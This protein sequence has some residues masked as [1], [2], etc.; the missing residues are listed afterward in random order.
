[1]SVFTNHPER[2]EEGFT[3]TKYRRLQ[4]KSDSHNKGD[5]TA[6]Y[7]EVALVMAGAFHYYFSYE[8][9]QVTCTRAGGCHLLVVPVHWRVGALAGE[10]GGYSVLCIRSR[11]ILENL[12][13][14]LSCC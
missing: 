11:L 13:T 5:D 14:F 9:R 8:D 12:S 1:M 3:R 6:L 7:V 4:W 10:V 2:P